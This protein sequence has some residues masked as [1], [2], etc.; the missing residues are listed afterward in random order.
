ME[1]DIP[2]NLFIRELAAR[3]R[4]ILLGG[5]AV[6]AH[7]FSRQTKDFNIWLEPLGS[8]QEWA[9]MLLATVHIFPEAKLWSLAQRRELADAELAAEAE[10][11]GVVR[12]NGFALPVD[13]FRKPNEMKPEDFERVWAATRRMDDKVALPNEIDL[14]VT[15][16]NT[17]REHDWQDRPFF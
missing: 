7:G 10:D 12:I 15:K 11:F 14:Y 8:V 9:A 17:D 3:H 4:V 1:A 16:A 13:V 6:I 2:K 5:M